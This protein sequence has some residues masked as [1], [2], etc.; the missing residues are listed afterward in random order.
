M[1]FNNLIL[2]KMYFSLINLFASKSLN[3]NKQSNLVDLINLD[4]NK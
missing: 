1:N 2:L 3:N 4:K